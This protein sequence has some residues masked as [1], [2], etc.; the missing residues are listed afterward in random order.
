[1]RS[2]SGVPIPP[3]S[4]RAVEAASA[5]YL[6]FICAN[7][8]YG[9]DILRVQEIRG[10]SAVTQLPE[11]PADVKGVMNLRGTIVPIVDLRILFGLESRLAGASTVVIVLR[12]QDEFVQRIVGVSV[13]GVSDVH[14]VANDA[15]MAAPD[16]GGSS[17]GGCV[18]GLVTLDGKTVVL[19]NIDR[20]LKPLNAAG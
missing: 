9:V 14:D 5:Q 8:E 19:L 7:E 12:V 6:T 13:D 3:E 10:W 18:S 15:I 11:S 1:M 2:S 20:L 16:L 17:D 4:K